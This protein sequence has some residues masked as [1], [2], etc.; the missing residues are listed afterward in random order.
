MHKRREIATELLGKM[1][2]STENKA[3]DSPLSESSVPLKL[4]EIQKLSMALAWPAHGFIACGE[5]G[6]FVQKSD[7]YTNESKMSAYS[8]GQSFVISGPLLGMR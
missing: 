8:Q 5:Y 3:M 6:P 2:N 4:S 7:C 1:R